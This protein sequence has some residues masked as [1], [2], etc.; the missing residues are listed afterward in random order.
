MKAPFLCK[1]EAAELHLFSNPLIYQ[2]NTA[3]CQFQDVCKG[4]RQPKRGQKSRKSIILL[5]IFLV[6]FR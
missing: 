3:Q 2:R 4:K 5:Y 1:Q 6:I